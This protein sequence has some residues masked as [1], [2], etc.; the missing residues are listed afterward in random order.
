MSV[1]DFG[2]LVPIEEGKT[3][4]VR[5]LAIGTVTAEGARDV[6]WELNVSISPYPFRLPD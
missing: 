3:L 2:L 5:L 6:W 4:I 1:A